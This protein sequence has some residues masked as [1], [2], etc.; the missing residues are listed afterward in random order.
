M[1]KA[2]KTVDLPEKI[3]EIP[4]LCFYYCESLNNIE[5]PTKVHTIKR[6]A[7]IGCIKLPQITIPKNVVNIENYA[8]SGCSSLKEVHFH[9]SD[10]QSESETFSGCSNL[11]SIYVHDINANSTSL[12]FSEG[13]YM[14]STLYVPKGTKMLYQNADGWKKFS[15]IEEFEDA[16]DILPITNNIRN[17]Q[18]TEFYDLN[19]I[20]HYSTKGKGI[21]I[22]NGKKVIMK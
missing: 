20:K 13:V 2:L 19:G 11:K 16:T 9:R 1:D 8:F 21:Y 7:F 3:E 17:E 18:N 15:N 22:V 5:I 4:P 10:I 12:I 6:S 14:F